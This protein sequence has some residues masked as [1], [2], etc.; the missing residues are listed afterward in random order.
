MVILLCGTTATESSPV[1]AE[2]PRVIA[3]ADP[4]PNLLLLEPGRS[5]PDLDPGLSPLLEPR[6]S[7][8]PE[9]KLRSL[10]IEFKSSGPSPN[11][12]SSTI[13]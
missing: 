3:P 13:D 1:E 2:R 5:P 6:R 8:P 12:R 11:R 10:P 4:R 9:V 7:E